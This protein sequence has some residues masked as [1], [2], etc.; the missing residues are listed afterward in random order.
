VGHYVG[1]RFAAKL[2]PEFVEVIRRLNNVPIGWAPSSWDW[3]LLK[4]PKDHFLVF[5]AKQDR[6]ISIPFGPPSGMP[7]DWD[8][9]NDLSGDTWS[10]CCSSKNAQTIEY[11]LSEVLP[12]MSLEVPFCETCI[13][14]GHP[15]YAPE[16]CGPKTRQV[17]PAMLSLGKALR[18]LDKLNSASRG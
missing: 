8:H 16:H 2:K 5:W 1:L 12:T 18:E 17:D 4:L 11:F 10:V 14:R 9:K 7:E 6:A 13:E 3:A 15:E